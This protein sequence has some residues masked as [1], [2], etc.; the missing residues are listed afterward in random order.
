ARRAGEIAAPDA[1][2]SPAAPAVAL[3]APTDQA[4]VNAALEQALAQARTADADFA[5]D[6]PAVET[7][8]AAAANTERGS[9]PWA[10]AS[11][12]LAGLEMHRAQLGSQIALVERLYVDDRMAYPDDTDSASR[13]LSGVLNAAR[14]TLDGMAQAQDRTLARLGARLR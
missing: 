7:Q 1:P 6:V 12:G 9:Q 4:S 14:A 2:A 5:R 11:I 13:P 3:P 8:L 10:K